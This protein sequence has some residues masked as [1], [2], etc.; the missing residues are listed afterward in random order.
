MVE[1]HIVGKGSQDRFVRG[2]QKAEGLISRFRRR[3]RESDVLSLLQ[4]RQKGWFGAKSTP[5]SR[6][7]NAKNPAYFTGFL[8][9]EKFAAGF[10]F[11]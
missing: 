3:V 10:A 9:Q 2:Q 8:L 7:Q 5:N 11:F 4:K 1:T 6:R